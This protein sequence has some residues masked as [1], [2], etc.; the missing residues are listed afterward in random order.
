MIK[1]IRLSLVLPQLYFLWSIYYGFKNI[2][3][4]NVSLLL[5]YISI[6]I[7]SLSEQISP[8]ENNHSINILL[9]T[10]P[11]I[12]ILQYTYDTYDGYVLM[13]IFITLCLILIC[14]NV[15]YLGIYY[16]VKEK[17]ERY[18]GGLPFTKDEEELYLEIFID[19]YFKKNKCTCQ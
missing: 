4:M 7:T 2:Y 8:I 18:Y 19:K 13:I 12:I 17:Y 3:V 6:I 11:Y 9:I 15:T 10:I 5:L 16:L 1:I 14:H